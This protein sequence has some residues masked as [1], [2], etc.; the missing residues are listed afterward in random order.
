MTE[1]RVPS[2]TSARV[3][4]LLGQSALQAFR[5]DLPPGGEPTADDGVAVMVASLLRQSLAGGP[6]AEGGRVRAEATAMA[7]RSLGEE[8]LA[9]GCTYD[10]QP[11]ETETDVLRLLAQRTEHAGRVLLAEHILESIVEFCD[12]PIAGG[13]LLSDRSRVSRKRG[14]LDLSLAQNEELLRVAKRLKSD[15]LAV[16]ALI[17]LSGLAQTRGNYAGMREYSAEAL[18]VSRR[19]GLRKGQA[20]A[21]EGLGTAASVVGDQNSAVN[22]YWSAYRLV[23]GKGV[24]AGA[25][26][27]NLAQALLMAG[28]FEDARKIATMLLNMRP[29]LQV[30]LPVLG[31]Y[32][33][34]SARLG[35][36]AAVEWACG[37]VRGLAKSRHYAREIASALIECSWALEVIGKGVQAG[38]LRRRAENIATTH[39]FHD[40]TFDEAPLSRPGA[41]ARQQ[42]TGEA[43]SAKSEIERLEVIGMPADLQP[44]GA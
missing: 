20:T 11:A 14:L 35:D 23:S 41:A 40:I 25:A 32:A 4:E 9:F 19:A 31:G 34:A 24:I 10:D 22:H 38:V 8:F 26:L 28:H 3:S 27:G 1:R 7:R 29:M 2:K 18:A 16:R 17:G 44:L 36:N 33:L 43:A 12:D 13:R 5:A 6:S 30:S 42:F 39:G 15:D 21:H 37:Q